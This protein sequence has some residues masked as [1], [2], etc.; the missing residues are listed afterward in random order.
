V[1]AGETSAAGFPLKNP[2]QSQI[3]GGLDCDVTDFQNGGS[4]GT[5]QCTDA[6]L[7]KFTPDGRSLVFSTLYG[8][9][10]NNSFVA[11]ALDSEDNIYANGQVP[12]STDLAGTAGAVQPQPGQAEDFQV[13]RFSP[14]GKLL[15][16]TYLGGTG[17][18]FAASIAVERPGVV[19][20][21]GQTHAKDMP[22][23]K[24]AYQPA[25]QSLAT[26]AYLARIDMNQSGPAGLTYATFFGG[27][28]GNSDLNHLF[29]DSSGQVVFC[30]EAVANIPTTTT[31]M[32]PTAPGAPVSRITGRYFTAVDGYIAR[33]NPA[34]SGS[35]QLTYSSYVGGTDVDTATNCAAD[36]HGYLVVAGNTLSSEPFWTAGSPFPYKDSGVGYNSY[37]IRIDPTTAGGRVDSIWFGGVDND[38]LTAMA[39]DNHG[40]AYLT[41]YTFSRQYPVTS[42]APQKLYGG[43][44]SIWSGS[45]VNPGAGTGDAWM[46]QV[47]LDGQA[48][49]AALGADSGDFQFGAA[50]SVLAPADGAP[51]GRGWKHSASGRL[52]GH[53]HRDQRNGRLHC[54]NQW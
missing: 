27:S 44:T 13:V 46:A 23:T 9:R 42:G 19:W 1:V 11:L 38:V 53:L 30:G 37:T 21:G 16:S 47:K 25:F 4:T 5:A 34:L 10:W 50:G 43:D 6:F 45:Q 49:V 48:A 3:S 32:Q 14:A 33:I 20:I 26:V 12:G 40:S 18:A 2:F 15:Y 52:S 8:G 31:A 39:L 36:D 29:L 35:A 22:T 41:G 7:S 28:G 54:Y 17:D 51:D 24:N